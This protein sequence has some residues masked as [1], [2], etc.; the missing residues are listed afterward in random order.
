MTSTPSIP[1]LPDN[2]G[3]PLVPREVRSARI[4]VA[5]LFLTNGGL[6][7][8]LLPRYP[9]IKADLDLT[10][11]AYGLAVASFPLGALIAG[12]AAGALIRRFRSSRVAVTGT[13]VTASGVLAAGLAPS[14][15]ALAAALFIAGAMDAITDVAQNSHGLRVQRQFGRSIINSFHAVWSVGAVIG[16]L[17]GGVAA[18]AD[19]PRGIHLGIS[20]LVFA[21]V[22]LVAYRFLLRGPEPLE[23]ADA[24]DARA[25][26]NAQRGLGS[27]RVRLALMLAA[28]VIIA[29]AGALVE[30]AG[31][32]W[33]TLYLSND[34]GVAVSLAALGYVAL[35]GF[36]FIGRLLGDGLVDRFGQRTVA[37]AGGVI[38]FAGMG[39]ALLFPTVVGTI[40]GFGLAGLGVATLIPA[41]MHE[42]DELPGLRPG[43]GLTVVSWLLRIG[44]LVSPPVVGLIADASSLRIGLLVVPVAGILVVA[45]AGV[46]AAKRP[47]STLRSPTSTDTT[48]AD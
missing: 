28:L 5:A 45:V 31:S 12:L 20:G 46:L 11:A 6:F 48:S 34:L 26:L 7:A 39:L 1:D 44:F 17:M 40:I 43:T 23:S 25:E 21:I 30:D 15:V 38:V 41:A 22:S 37:R 18:G 27:H 32:T 42:A 13:I 9:Q 47:S 14:W 8:N 33:A 16:G 24:Q 2:A 29:I 35:V 10:N 19:I 36:Q 3:R 4:A